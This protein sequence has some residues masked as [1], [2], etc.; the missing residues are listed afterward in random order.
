[1]PASEQKQWWPD[2]RPRGWVLMG[3]SACWVLIPR[4]AGVLLAYVNV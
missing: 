2:R 1:M 4:A 3:Q